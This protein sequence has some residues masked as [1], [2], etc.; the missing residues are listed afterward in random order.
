[1]T[2]LKVLIKRYGT[3]WVKISHIMQRTSFNIRDKWK[4]IS[5]SGKFKRNKTWTFEEI[6]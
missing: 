5:N 6:I 4:E 2:N 1:M 3:E